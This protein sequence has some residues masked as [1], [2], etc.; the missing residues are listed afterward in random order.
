M[1]EYEPG[2]IHT[3]GSFDLSMRFHGNASLDSH[4]KRL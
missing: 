4:G 1:N 2:S 3:Y